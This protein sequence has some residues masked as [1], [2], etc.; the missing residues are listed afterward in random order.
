MAESVALDPVDLEILRLLQ[1]DARMT[2]RELATS[3]GIAASTCL[4]RVGRL[5]RSGVILGHAL[6]LDPA[7][8]GR[9]LE[10]LLMVQVRPHR[11]ELIGPFVDRVRALPESRA[12]FHLTGP[13]DYLVHVA[14]TGAADL[15]RLVLD[16]FTS[17][18]E[19]ARV[20]TRLI[21]QQ[22]SCGPLLPPT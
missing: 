4:D 14:V 15:Q 11:R 19:V 12:L 9:S 1:N 18:R 22:W 8:L 5:R 16:E 20:D 10:A 17:R 13:D 3:V 2:Y 7:R 6:R 21:F